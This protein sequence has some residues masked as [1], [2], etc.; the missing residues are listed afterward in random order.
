MNVLIDAFP[1][2]RAYLEEIITLAGMSRVYA[3]IHYRFDLDAGK[4][5][6]R[7]AAALALAGSL[8]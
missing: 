2:E 4:E 6:G 3:G 1:S 8:E 5:I 7:Q